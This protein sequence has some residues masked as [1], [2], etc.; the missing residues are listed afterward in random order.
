M[1]REPKLIVAVGKKGVGKTYLTE[2][3]I[4]QYV[5]GNPSKGVPPRRALILDVNDEFSS[6]KAIAI[7]DVIKFSENI[8]I[9]HKNLISAEQCIS[10]SSRYGG[11]FLHEGQWVLF[12]N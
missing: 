5:K 11:I 2:R 7:N 8:S 1:G 6:I 10:N 4:Q 9:N 12:K 3:I